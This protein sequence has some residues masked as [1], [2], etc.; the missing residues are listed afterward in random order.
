MSL[1]NHCDEFLLLFANICAKN[2]LYSWKV[3]SIEAFRQENDE[4]IKDNF[5]VK[6]PSYYDR[7]FHSIYDLFSLSAI[8][9]KISIHS[10]LCNVHVWCTAIYYLR[11][12]Y[13]KILAPS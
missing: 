7:F 1:K 5:A 10:P 2:P 3:F 4:K 11:K 8:M 9:Y 13:E 6:L 12:V